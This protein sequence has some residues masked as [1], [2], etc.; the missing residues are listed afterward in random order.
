MPLPPPL[1]PPDEMR[2]MAQAY[3]GNAAHLRDYLERCAACGLP[4]ETRVATLNQQCEFC[5]RFLK[6]FF[7]DQT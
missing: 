7:A 1:Q 6:Q 4:T 3:L 2:E 5:D